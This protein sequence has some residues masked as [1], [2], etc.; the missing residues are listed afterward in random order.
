MMAHILSHRTH[1]GTFH[2]DGGGQPYALEFLSTDLLLRVL[3]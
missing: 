3:G 2:V 1:T